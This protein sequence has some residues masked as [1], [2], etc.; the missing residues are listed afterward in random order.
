MQKIT[1]LFLTKEYSTPLLKFALENY[2]NENVFRKNPFG[3]NRYLCS[4]NKIKSE[5]SHIAS[6]IWINI[7]RGLNFKDDDLN[8]EPVFGILLAVQTESAFVQYHTDPSPDG[9]SA[10][11]IN[12]L[13]SKP[14]RG[15]IPI[16][17]NKELDVQE[18]Q[19]W[20]NVSDEWFHGCTTVE[21]CKPRVILSLGATVPRSNPII[22]S[23][24]TS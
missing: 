7:Y 1:N 22:Q 6:D 16:I 24:L 11:R 21:G 2:K 14:E 9:F 13:L 4:L 12:C 23:Y 8:I 18:N 17:E 10:I 3:S 20:V 15:G 5:V 19:F